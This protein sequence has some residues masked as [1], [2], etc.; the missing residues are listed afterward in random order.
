MSADKE[1]GQE[2]EITNEDGKNRR[3]ESCLI[4]QLQFVHERRK[5][6]EKKNTHLK[7][8]GNRSK[9]PNKQSVHI[10]LLCKRINQ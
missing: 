1:K 5:K 8:C 2:V 10:A 3:K 9:Q 6:K 7:E 4:F